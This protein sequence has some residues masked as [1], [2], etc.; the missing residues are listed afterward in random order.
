MKKFFALLLS[1]IMIASSIPM[2]SIL[3]Y[4]DTKADVMPNSIVIGEPNPNGSGSANNP[5]NEA[6]E[7]AIKAVKAKIT[8]PKEYSK[9]D[10]YFYNTNS[11]ADS[12]WSLNWSNPIDSSNIQISC[13][14]NNHI[15]SYNIYNYSAKNDVLPV[16][17]KKELK[18]TAD[19]F[20]QKI[21]SETSSKLDYIEAAYLGVYSGNYIYNYQRIENE[22]IFPDNTVSVSVN[23]VTGEVRA[24]N[25]HWLYDVEVPA[26]DLKLTK[27]QAAKLIKENMTM[28]LVYR[29]DYYH[30]Y[31]N[32][33][34]EIR[35]AYL[36]YE[37]SINYIS[38]NAKTGK[39]YLT[40]SE[41]IDRNTAYGQE[42]AADDLGVKR[43][44]SAA[45]PALTEEEIAKI[46]ELKNLL[47]KEAAIK[48]ITDNKS[49]YLDK[50]LTAYSATLNK[51]NYTSTDSYIWNIQLSDPREINY[52][53]DTDYYRAYASAQVDAKTG[54]ILGFYASMKSQYDDATGKWKE[55]KIPYDKDECQAVLEKFLNNQIKSR[56]AK[57]KLVAQNDEY[58]V[59]YKGDVPVYG[60]YHYQYNRFNADVEYAYNSINGSVDGVTGKI[61]SYNYN[62]D[63]NVVFESPVG[64]M[65]PEQA[66]DQYLSK[67]GYGLVYEINVLNSYDPLDK[68]QTTLYDYTDTYSVDYEIRLVYTPAVNP[69]YISPFTGEQ[70]NYGGTVYKETKPYEYLDIA[71]TAENR[72]ILLFT[73]MNIGFEGDYFKPDSDITSAE[74]SELLQKV[75]YSYAESTE[76][77]SNTDKAITRE[78]LAQSLIEKLGLQKVSELQGIYRTGYADELNI[79]E[80]YFGAVAL[81]KGLGLM[82]ADANNNFNPK[83]NVTR[84]QTVHLILTFI[85]VQQGGIYY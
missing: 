38:I 9:F 40:K 26:A 23:S 41:W 81:A 4:G 47:S 79:N 21:A 11:Y 35:N 84:A 28:K 73:D 76:A 82:E 64:A 32:G 77:D 75:S 39:V 22:V 1:G 49:L 14:Q 67:D 66:M 15:T 61:Y 46:E 71:D 8:I 57:T 7:S 69:Y 17:L 34:R 2:G 19:A 70:L 62:W 60:G 16:Y 78:E 20:I 31:D 6:L 74:F 10:Y 83:N 25:L 30:I 44:E 13:D 51:S 3:A 36:V 5:S 12:Y 42:S 45:A 63:E 52:E 43:D 65:T 29:T 33:N 50:T 48:I 18:S 80:K 27:E 72:E 85:K 56:F 37:P 68:I 55:V 58:V 53:K 54:K 24:A 59:Y